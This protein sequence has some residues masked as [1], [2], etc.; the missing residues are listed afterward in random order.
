MVDFVQLVGIPPAIHSDDA[1]VFKYGE[2]HKSC[3]KYQIKQS[4][5]EP[6]SPWQNQAEGG[7]REL[8]SYAI[9][10]MQRV[11]APLRVWCFA[12]KYAAEVLSLCAPN[13]YPL[14]GR[15]SY[16]HVMNYTPDI[17]E[18]ISFEWFQ[19][20]YYW[21]EIKKEKVM[22]RWLGV[23]HSIGQSLCYYV[24]KLNGE[25]LARS[26][27]I[28]IPESDLH[29]NEIKQQMTEFT[30]KLH[31]AI[32]DHE[33][34]LVDDSVDLDKTQPYASC[35]DFD[36]AEDPVT[37]PWDENWKEIALH[38]ETAQ[39]QKELDTYIGAQVLMHNKY[40]NEVLCWVKGRKRYSDGSLIGEY[41][42]NPI[43]DTRIFD[44][45]YPDGRV[46]AFSTNLIAESLYSNVDDEGFD[47][48]LMDE[49]INHSM[50]DE[51][52]KIEDGLVGNNNTPVITT[53]GWKIQVKWI[54]GTSDWL[55]L[56]QVKNS[57]PVK[58]AEYAVMKGIDMQPAFRWWVKHII[59]KKHRMIN[60]VK[61]QMQ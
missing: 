29:S 26:T 1:K 41:N 42:P 53:K 45:E 19:W 22:C 58:L 11:Q 9:K 6:Y 60:K 32:S 25:F 34:A 50:T 33:K 39:S 2:F 16:E 43:L 4:F 28:P 7:I 52:V 37:Y 10:M 48:G 61:S 3:R 56:A 13:S 24:I 12:C 23:A 49:I 20:S 55:P 18:Y 27:V 59:K 38:D 51:A 30:N 46:E 21:D 8:K 44:V 35:L 5:T 15:T 47:T 17:S 40:G 14:M 36:P 54:D 31:A 57:N